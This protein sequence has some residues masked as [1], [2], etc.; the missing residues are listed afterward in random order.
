VF[1]AGYIRVPD[2]VK[3]GFRLNIA[4]IFVITLLAYVLVPLVFGHH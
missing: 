3:A 2:M 1:G 4:G